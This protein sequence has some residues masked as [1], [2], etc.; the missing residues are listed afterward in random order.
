M[1]LGVG[2]LSDVFTAWGK[3]WPV[4]PGVIVPPRSPSVAEGVGQRFRIPGPGSPWTT[5]LKFTCL[6]EESRRWI[7]G[8]ERFPRGRLS[9]AEGVGHIP[10]LFI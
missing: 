2:N 5:M 9:L 1:A 6:P 3:L 7:E 8:V 4:I 10:G